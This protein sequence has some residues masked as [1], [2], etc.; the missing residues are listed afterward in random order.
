MV[1]LEWYPYCRLKQNIK[2]KKCRKT[3]REE[4]IQVILPALR[5]RIFGFFS[6][7]SLWMAPES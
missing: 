6:F 7:R 5:M 2:K 4:S 1:G 3:L